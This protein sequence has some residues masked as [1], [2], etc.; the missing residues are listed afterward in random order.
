MV[1]LPEVQALAGEPGKLTDIDVQAE[2]GRHAQPSSNG[3]SACAGREGRPRPHGRGGLGAT[4]EGPRRHPRSSLTIGLLVFGLVALLVG[5]FV[6][7][8]TFSI[9]VA[10]R[11]REFGTLRTLGA[12]RRQVL[13]RSCSKR[14]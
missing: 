14:S 7:F 6:I 12:S 8:N 3:A 2:G 11:T 13:R 5:G 4:V 10:Q 9:T 1:T